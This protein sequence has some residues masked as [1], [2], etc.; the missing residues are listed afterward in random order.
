M[1]TLSAD[2]GLSNL[3]DCSITAYFQ[4]TECEQEGNIDP[5]RIQKM[6]GFLVNAAIVLFWL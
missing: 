5:G 3:M 6:M 4:P 2:W 1:F